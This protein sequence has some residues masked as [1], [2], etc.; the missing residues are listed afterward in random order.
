MFSKSTRLA[1]ARKCAD[2]LES[3]KRRYRQMQ[4]NAS[5]DKFKVIQD[6]IVAL[7]AAKI[8]IMYHFNLKLED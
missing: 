4:E 2:I 1:T 8:E 7:D 3:N 5:C 6:K